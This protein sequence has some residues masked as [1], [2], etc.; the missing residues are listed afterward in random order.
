MADYWMKLYIEILDDP[1]MATLPDRVWRR[2]IE[3]FLVAKRL[4]KDGHLPETRQIAWMLRMSPDELDADLAQVVHTGIIEREVGG[5]FIP[6]FAQR[7]APVPDAERKAQERD[8]K[9][10]RQY[11]GNVTDASRNVTQSTEDRLTE[12]ETDTDRKLS[13]PPDFRAL[14]ENTVA[15]KVYLGVTSMSALPS[16]MIDKSYQLWRFAI[17]RGGIEPAIE[18]LKPFYSDWITRKNKAGALYSKT[19]S[20]W[21]DWAISGEI[22]GK[23]EAAPITGRESRRRLLTGV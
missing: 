23:N 17:D 12:A 3:L 10:S 14:S 18:Y 19:G 4:G 8:R 21:V 6:K 11:Y 7:Q 9:K 16:S 22:P 1:K 13:S 2:V 5:W 20:G 15:E